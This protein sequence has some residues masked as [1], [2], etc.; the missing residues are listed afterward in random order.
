MLVAWP[1][2]LLE[3]SPKRRQI[4]NPFWQLSPSLFPEVVWGLL[5][6]EDVL[7]GFKCVPGRKGKRQESWLHTVIA[8]WTSDGPAEERS[9]VCPGQASERLSSVN[10]GM[11]MGFLPPSLMCLRSVQLGCF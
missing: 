11:L 6:S 1:N 7:L 4:L 2:V 5:C 8:L 10:F 3:P 9:L